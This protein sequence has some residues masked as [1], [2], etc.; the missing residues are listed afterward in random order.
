M[1]MLGSNMTLQEQ[2]NKKLMKIIGVIL[3]ILLVVCIGLGVY[4]SYLQ[5]LNLKVTIDGK[6][7]TNSLPSDI[8]VFENGTVY[9]SI[10]D[11]A[12]YV[13]YTPYNGDYK[14]YSEDTTK[15]YV[16][17]GK[18]VAS[19]SLNSNKIYKT[20]V[21]NKETENEYEY[22]S[23]EHPVKMMNGKLY[24][25]ADGIKIACNVDFTY[26]QENNKIEI[27][28]LPYLV[29]YYTNLTP[30]S[31]VAGDEADFS[32]QKALLYGMIVVRQDKE[33]EIYGVKDLN[34]G[35]EIIGTKYREIKFLESTKEFLIKTEDNKMGII[36]YNATTKIK[37]E[38]DSIKQIDKDLDLYLVTNNNKQGVVNKN[39]KVI[40]YLEYDK[41]GIDPTRF[42][43]N[44]IKNPYLLF[45]NC[46]PVQKNQKWGIF[47]KD[48][49]ILL[50]V[51]YDNIG[52]IA[53]TA[54]DRSAQNVLMI[55]EYEAIVIEKDKT[56]GI[57]N[58]LGRELIPLA[59]ANVYAI[60]NAGE[61]T[62]YMVH[63]EQKWDVIQYIKDYVKEVKPGTP[64]KETTNTVTNETTNT[65][66][67][68]TT[69]PQNQ[70]NQ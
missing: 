60:T 30:D 29:T 44:D 10:K 16:D 12:K 20:I 33:K 22:F 39:G 26:Q 65:T 15:C 51:E 37:P 68:T 50:P 38:Y 14:Q 5:S 58:S 24:A 59:L 3:V 8:F 19:F 54:K 1:D 32:N 57:I 62:Y 55:P 64:E 49:N 28:T 61:N 69:E 4:I 56:Y 46:I 42:P 25:S 21:V 66:G 47:D 11:F 43:S 70:A 48:G 52:C 40:V 36:S 2:K 41:I 53:S 27:F 18:E 23:M 63:G 31:A 9:V 7:V 35:K 45:D 13:G 6:V 17:N 67:N 34:T